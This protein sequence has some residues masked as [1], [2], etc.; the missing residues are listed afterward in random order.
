MRPCGRPSGVCH[1]VD[2]SQDRP[3]GSPCRDDQTKCVSCRHG[4]SF[5]CHGKPAAGRRPVGCPRVHWAEPMGGGHRRPNRCPVRSRFPQERW[6]GLWGRRGWGWTRE[7]KNFCESE[8]VQGVGRRV[9]HV[10]STSGVLVAAPHPYPLPVNRERG[11]QR[12]RQAPLIRPRYARPPSPTRGEGKTFAAAS[13]NL[14]CLRL[15]LRNARA[16]PSPLV[17]EGGRTE[18][19]EGEVG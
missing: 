7:V 16:S 19:R 10:S 4:C 8:R 14:K 12:L 9:V 3:M 6:D 1:P 13:A 18:Q 15:E 11:R 17:G 5:L 2:R